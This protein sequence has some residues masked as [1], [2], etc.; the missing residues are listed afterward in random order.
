M[1]IDKALITNLDIDPTQ[2]FSMT[3]NPQPPAAY[4]FLDGDED[5]FLPRY[6][7]YEV[8]MCDP[9]NPV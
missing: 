4:R 5:H 7:W 6:L 2:S 8:V 1:S 3:M 9:G